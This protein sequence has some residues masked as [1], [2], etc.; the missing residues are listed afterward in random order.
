MWASKAS[1]MKATASKKQ[2]QVCCTH[3]AEN[4]WNK[5]EE[6]EQNKNKTL[7]INYEIANYW[8]RQ[9]AI[10]NINVNSVEDAECKRK[11]MRIDVKQSG[12]IT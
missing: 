5:I 7:N 2:L 4:K 6:N 9:S 12:F 3:E 1:M 11:Q 10:T 8:T